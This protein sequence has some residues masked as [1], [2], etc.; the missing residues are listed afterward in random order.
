M[1][2]T[3]ALVAS[4]STAPLFVEKPYLQLGEFYEGKSLELVWQTQADDSAG[5]EVRVTQEGAA[6]RKFGSKS[7]LVDMVNVPNYRI[8]RAEL[9]DFAPGKAF[10]YEV[11]H[12]GKSV[13]QGEAMAPKTAAQPYRMVVFGDC[14]VGSKEQR[15]VAYQAGLAKPDKVLITGDIVYNTGRVSEYRDKFFPVYNPDVDSPET[16]SRLLSRSLVVGAAGNHDLA[17]GDLWV[18]PDRYAY[19]FNWYQPLNGPSF[20]FNKSGVPSIVGSREAIQRLIQASGPRFLK[21]QNFSYD[22]GNTHFLILDSNPYVNWAEPR[23]RQWVKSDLAKSRAKWKVVVYHHPGFHSSPTH[24]AQKQMRVL[25]DAFEDGGV[26]LVLNGHVH[27]Y[28]RTFPIQAEGKRGV[29]KEELEK[30]DWKVDRSFDGVSVLRPKG[31]IYLVD[32]GGGAGL[33]NRELNDQPDKW[34]PFQAKY[35]AQHSFSVIDVNGGTL[36]LKQIN[37]KGDTVDEFKIQK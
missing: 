3:L 23:L 26:D 33:Y 8:H 21:S 22:Y 6:A 31:V 14:S 20:Q 11:L 35:I 7:A 34:N 18:Q 5:Y 32:G 27:N 28:Q 16:G 12:E 9:T 36:S 4:L 2:N 15:Q 37:I 24:Q 17:H 1:L 25:A 30:N 19:F 13:F 29:S 10:S